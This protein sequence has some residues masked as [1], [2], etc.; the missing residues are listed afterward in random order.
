MSKFREEDHPRENDGKFT[1][2]GMSDRLADH[3]DR[4]MDAL[5]NGKDKH[6]DNKE[7]EIKALTQIANG[8]SG[9]DRIKA[10]DRS[11]A[12]RILRQEHGVELAPQKKEAKEKLTEKEKIMAA[13]RK[14]K[15][16]DDDSGGGMDRPMRES[17]MS[18][19]GILFITKEGEVLLMRRAARPD[20]DADCQGCWSLPGGGIEEG[21][22][23]EEAARREVFE[24]TG[25]QFGGPL[26]LWTRRIKDGVDF[27]TFI[28]VV[29]KFPIAMNDEHDRY[30]WAD[31]V[32]A[33]TSVSLHPGLNVALARFDMDELGV[34]KAMRDGELTSPQRY[35]KD[36]LLVAMRITGTGL[37]YRSAHEQYVWRDS[38]IYMNAEFLERCNGLP[39]IFHHP[40]GNMLNTEEFRDRIVGTIFVPYFKGADEV[41]GIAKI[42]DMRAGELLTEEVMSTSPAVMC[43]GEK[44]VTAEGETILFENKPWLLDHLAVLIGVPGVWDKGAG[45][46]G[47]DSVDATATPE[48]GSLDSLDVIM[49]KILNQKIDA[50]VRA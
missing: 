27:C 32:F 41:W 10:S 2:G 50:I 31:R 39:V 1:A 25:F 22:T 12:R 5:L 47:V 19:A 4:E 11:E 35:N 9:D 15:V 46:Q 49:S 23:A 37:S 20:Q 44:F 43:I 38:S 48:P 33:A 6:P 28:A 40:D 45:P 42:L 26:A 30:T 13:T 16:A 7:T 21:E 29:E 17:V 8:A 14:I 34:A 36:L 3:F 18:A 24:E